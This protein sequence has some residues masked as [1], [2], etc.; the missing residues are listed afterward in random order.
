M[1]SSEPKHHSEKFLPWLAGLFFLVVTVFFFRH[2]LSLSGT[3]V[4]SKITD[5]LAGQFVWWRQFGFDELKK[6]HLALW[7]PR[8]Y[9][10]EPFFGGF[11]SALLYPPN[12]LFMCLPL[13]FALNFSM[14]LHVFLAGWFTYLW[15]S[16]RGSHPVSALMGGLMFMFGAAYVL[17]L[18]PGHL[19]NLCTMVWIPL[20]FLAIDQY[21]KELKTKWILMG[22]AVMALQVFSGH[23]QYVY[24]TGVITAIYALCNLPEKKK[25]QFLGGISLIY[26][27]AV[28][29]SAVQL[30]AGWAAMVEGARSQTLDI[31]FL[32]IADI[33]PERLW[34]LLMPEFFGGYQAYWGGGMYHEGVVFVSVTAF[35]LALF[36]LKVSPN[37]QKKFFVFLILGMLAVAVGTRLPFFVLFCKYF[38]LFDHFRGIGKLNIF[39]TICLIALSAMGM[40]EV[41]RNPSSL[42]KLASGAFKGAL[43]FMAVGFIFVI[44]PRFGLPRHFDPFLIHIPQMVWGIW[45]CALTLLVLAGMALLGLRWKPMRYGFVALAF[46]ELFTFASANLP[47]FDL[48]ALRKE[49]SKIQTLYDQDPGDYRVYTR[50][51]NYALGTTGGSV[52]GDDPAFT[53]R[54]NRFSTQKENNRFYYP[55]EDDANPPW[56][57]AMEMTRL[58]YVLFKEQGSWVPEKT[59]LHPVARAELVHHWTVKPMDEV[60]PALMDSRFNPRE[61]VYLESDPGMQTGSAKQKGQV[62]LKDISSDAVEISAQVASPQI[63]VISDCYSKDWKASAAADSTQRTYRVMPANGFQMGIP[64]ESGTHHFV[65]QYRPHAF[66]IG[67]WI[68]WI[69][70]FL[71]IGVF[72]FTVP[73][74]RRP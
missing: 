48:T 46:L 3:M 63:L 27:G 23:I 18:V 73:L 30:M 2:F 72:F 4:V 34:C 58:K 53:L 11:Q 55:H 44:V 50:S 21:R 35:V 42:G 12:W 66:V 70:W 25:L 57:K 45:Q 1:D 8:L 13:P 33:S 5:D 36:A 19:P 24:Y 69:A 65:L 61:S 54:Y 26:I 62:A 29:L 16:A 32:D 28:L 52:W 17:H 51:T 74:S 37:Q 71:W 20:I 9:C 41:F 64:L 49:V 60:F 40:D 68:S 22:M 38:P 31:G 59:G 43:V 14:A 7:N 56:S 15:V 47:S 39:I 6:G 10:G 67:S